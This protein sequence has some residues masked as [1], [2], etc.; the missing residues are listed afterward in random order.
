MQFWGNC[1][2]F[3]ACKIHEI[4]DLFQESFSVRF[5]GFMSIFWR[6]W[7]DFLGFLSNFIGCFDGIFPELFILEALWNEFK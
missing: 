1:L 2:Q 7:E 6:W 4:I 3:D 5:L